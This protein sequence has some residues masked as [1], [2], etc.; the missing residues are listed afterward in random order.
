MLANWNKWFPKCEPIAH[1]LRAAFIERW[2]RFHSLPESKRYP[3]DEQEFAAVLG[4]HNRIIEN[5]ADP[6]EVVVLLTTGYSESSDPVRLDEAFSALDPHASPWRTV[7]MH[8]VDGDFCEPCYWHI[9][10]SEWQWRPHTFD[11]LVRLVADDVLAN[12]MIVAGDCRWLLHP[13]DGG[14]DVILESTRRRDE[15]KSKHQDW[16]SPRDDGL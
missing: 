10:T 12:I 5:L 3:A 9:F 11:A 16:L 8:Q 4:R 6:G 7:P 13:Y 15:M 1:H 14:M 2:V